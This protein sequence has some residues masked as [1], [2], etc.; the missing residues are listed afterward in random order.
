MMGET[1]DNRQIGIRTML[2][3]RFHGHAVYEQALMRMPAGTTKIEIAIKDRA[4]CVVSDMG[5]SGQHGLSMQPNLDKPL[6]R[7]ELCVVALTNEEIG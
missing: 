5:K 6:W 3:D 7:W 2:Q 4:P 1:I